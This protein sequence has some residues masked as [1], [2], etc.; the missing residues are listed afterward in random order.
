MGKVHLTKTLIDNS[1]FEGN[2]HGAYVLWDDK[3][4]GFGIRIYPSGKKSF[5]LKYRVYGRQ[6]NM[7]IG[8]YGR[9][10]TLHQARNIAIQKLGEINGGKDPLAIKQAKFKSYTVEKLAN[11]YL[12]E[13][14]KVYK[15]S[16]KNDKSQIDKIILEEW[17][18]RKASSITRVDVDRL[19][20]KIG[21]NNGKYQA[22]RTLATISKMFEL[23]IGWGILEAGSIN[24]ARGIEK[25]KEEKRHRAID[26][27]EL[28]RLAKA[29]E[30]EE[31]PYVKAAIWLLLFIGCRKNELLTAKWE[32]VNFEKRIITF[33]E[34]KS[35]RSYS[36]PLSTRAIEI[37][38]NLPQEKENP[39]ILPGRKYGHH[40]VNLMKPWQR[41]LAKAG[42]PKTIR[43]HDLRHTFGTSLSNTG[44]SLTIVGA[45]MN[46][47]QPSVTARYALP[48][49]DP[50]RV[51]VEEHANWLESASKGKAGEIIHLQQAVKE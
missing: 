18:N 15:K 27:K 22:N 7:V 19:H 37:L 1:T 9:Q 43:L 17:K 28:P 47:S 10:M 21:Q 25:F 6:R 49:E 3:T 29:I 24:P 16:W 38:Q 39:Y 4:A 51:A 46:H 32:F 23:A 2:N 11:K 48:S 34:T 36:A 35:G 13:H 44:A 14:A 20:K 8:Q 42:L 26:A 31:S 40:L 12:K 33:P 5:M 45:A 50:I 30:T 41:I